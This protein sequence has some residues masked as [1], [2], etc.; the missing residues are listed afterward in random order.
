M[1]RGGIL[2][3]L[4]FNGL[5]SVL[6]Y[7]ASVAVF[8]YQL[9]AGQYKVKP[10][11]VSL[12]N[13]ERLNRPPFDKLKTQGER[14]SL[15]RYVSRLKLVALYSV[16]QETECAMTVAPPLRYWRGGAHRLD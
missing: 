14:L 6:T 2:G 16:E 15:W 11:M 1:S 12:S 4:E 8:G 5:I 13:H 10:F 9:K 3:V 7:G